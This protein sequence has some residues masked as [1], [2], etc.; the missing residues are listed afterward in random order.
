MITDKDIKNAIK[1]CRYRKNAAGI[2]FCALCVLPC[3]RTMEKRDCLA[4]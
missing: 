1:K 3:E 2:D 4:L